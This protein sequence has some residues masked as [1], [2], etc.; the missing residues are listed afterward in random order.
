MNYDAIKIADVAPSNHLNEKLYIST[1][2][3]IFVLMALIVLQVIDLG[4]YGPLGPSWSEFFLLL[5][6]SAD[7]LALN[8]KLELSLHV[9]IERNLP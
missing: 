2:L 9:R 5:V 4:V 1:C 7:D 3:G 6:R 8:W